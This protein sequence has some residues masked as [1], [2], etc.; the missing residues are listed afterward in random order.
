MADDISKM[1]ADLQVGQ[2]IAPR[3]VPEYDADTDKL[4]SQEEFFRPPVRFGSVPVEEKPLGFD[5]RRGYKKLFPPI[6]LPTQVVERVTFGNPELQPNRLFW[7]DNLHVMRS[8]PPESIDLIYIDPPFFSGRNYNVIFGDKNELRSFTDIWEGGMSGY[9]IWLNARLV[10]MK[11]LLRK[12]GSIFVHLDW[13]A[14]HY[15][16]TEMDKIFGFD[17]FRNEII[18]SYPGREKIQKQKLQSKHDTILFYSKSKAFELNPLTKEWDRTERIKALRRK[19]HKDEDGTEWFWE[20]RGQAHG[21]EAYKRD[22]NEYLGK[23]GALNDCWDDIQF[24]RGNHPERIGYPTQKPRLLLERIIKLVTDEGDTVADFFVGGGTTI[25]TA[26]KHNRRWIGCDQ[27]RVAVAIG[28]DRVIETCSQQNSDFPHP[29]FTLE[30]WGI[31]EMDRLSKTP[32]EGFREFVLRAYGAIPDSSEPGIHGRKG[33]VPIW[34]GEPSLK[35]KVTAEHVVGFANAIKKSIRYQQDNLRDGVM[36]AWSFRPDAL[37]AAAE[38]REREHTTLDFI[39]LENVPIDSPQFREH[40]T[41]LTTEHADYENFLTFVQPPK[42]ELGY[43]KLSNKTYVFDVSE[44]AL[45]NPGAQ[46]INVQWDFD[47]RDRFSSTQGYSFVRTPQGSPIMKAEYTFNSP[48]KKRIAVKVQDDL[49]G[50]GMHLE[51]IVVD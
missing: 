34:V 35:S 36:L 6:L 9:L 31:Y 38:L 49:G 47:Y 17:N 19:I 2:F 27:S 22:L 51:D 3:E 42:V 37:Q 21:I 30:H 15:V 48:G 50:E 33:A 39:R 8:L 14:V 41:A 25:A 45:M 29:D 26:A 10:E 20:T 23:G 43:K 44:T 28:A 46:I 18:W 40:I 16:K 1:N 12:T 5:A 32:P 24:L 7:G 11:R 13:H 4:P